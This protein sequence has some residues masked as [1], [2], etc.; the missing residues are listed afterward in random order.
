[1]SIKANKAMLALPL[2]VLGSI[3]FCRRNV[4]AGVIT[5]GNDGGEISTFDDI[6]MEEFQNWYATALL[7]HVSRTSTSPGVIS[8]SIG[9]EREVWLNSFSVI[10]DEIID[11]DETWID[12]HRF[13]GILGG[14]YPLNPK[15]PV[16]LAYQLILQLKMSTSLQYINTFGMQACH[17][18]QAHVSRAIFELFNVKIIEDEEM[19]RESLSVEDPPNIFTEF[20]GLGINT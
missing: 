6:D 1:M 4:F 8:Y 3:I 14:D 16:I 7:L 17:D 11:F 13:V 10:E 12:G 18:F 19:H 5:I 9:D 20:H 2:I 15:I